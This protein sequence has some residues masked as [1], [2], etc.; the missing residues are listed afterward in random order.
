MAFDEIAFNHER[1]RIHQMANPNKTYNPWDERLDKDDNL[2]M[3]I[4]C[5]FE[6]VAEGLVSSETTRV[7]RLDANR[8]KDSVIRNAFLAI[9]GIIPFN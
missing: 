9:E 1:R 6:R 3:R 4:M 7:V 8:S 2:G 5:S